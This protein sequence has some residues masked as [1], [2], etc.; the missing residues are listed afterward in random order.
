MRRRLG[1]TLIELLVVIAIIAVLVALL[2]PAVQQA[3]EAARRSQCRNNLKQW[4]LAM[5]NYEEINRMLPFASTNN[6]RHTF[7]VSLWPQLDQLALFDKYDFNTHF[8]LPPNTVTNSLSGVIANRL[9]IYSCPSDR[10]GIWQGDAYWRARGSYVV[11]WG[12]RTRPWTTTPTNKAAFGWTND[13]IANPQSTRFR[14]FTDGL[15]NCLLMAEI[16]MAKTDTAYDMRGDFLNDDGN[17]SNHQFMT[18]NTPNG[19][20]DVNICV[21]TNDAAMPCIAGANK[22]ATA[23][24]RHVGGVHAL[25]GDGVVRLVGDNVDLATWRSLSTIDGSESISDY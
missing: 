15:S 24:S 22:H 2:L 16:L 17:F 19:G 7:V 8:Y 14:D 18:I 6:R 25:F 3:R 9:P 1:F 11:S 10:E 23:R 21:V 20:V 12:D 4:G 13:N 5:H